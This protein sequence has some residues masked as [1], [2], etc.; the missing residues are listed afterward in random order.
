M[1]ETIEEAE[2]VDRMFERLLAA[3]VCEFCSGYFANRT[4]MRLAIT[5]QHRQCADRID[6]AV[7]DKWP[8]WTVKRYMTVRKPSL[9]RGNAKPRRGP[10]S[11]NGVRVGRVGY[12]ELSPLS[13]TCLP[14][15]KEFTP[16]RSGT[17]FCSV[18]CK[19]RAWRDRA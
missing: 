14:C 13:V 1:H 9:T 4:G 18:R 2:S 19:Q 8:M 10:K 17:K 3:G 6:A 12:G 16:A 7:T 5:V 15:G 11:G